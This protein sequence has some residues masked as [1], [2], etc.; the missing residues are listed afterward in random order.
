MED[1]IIKESR[2]KELDSLVYCSYESCKN[3]FKVILD[4]S[5]AEFCYLL[6]IAYPFIIQ[7][8]K[9]YQS[10]NNFKLIN[11]K[12]K[13]LLGTKLWWK[14]HELTMRQERIDFL[15]TNLYEVK[16]IGERIDHLP[17]RIIYSISNWSNSNIENKLLKIIH[18]RY[19]KENC[20]LDM[21][22][23]QLVDENNIP[24]GIYHQPLSGEIVDNWCPL[25][26]FSSEVKIA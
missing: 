1:Q 2:L 23:G 22:E 9:Y 15:L 17:F 5:D 24:F 10:D 19:A 21:V 18:L 25:T 3:I 6:K 14:I 26:Y 20:C 16:I 11:E 13:I 4:L 12:C 7:Y 8:Y